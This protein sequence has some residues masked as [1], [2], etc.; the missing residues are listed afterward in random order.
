MASERLQSLEQQL[1]NVTKAQDRIN[2]MLDICAEW[3]LYDVEK[4]KQL[5]DEALALSR[6]EDY[7]LGIGRSLYAIGSSLWQLGD[8]AHA[9][10]FLN[11]A[12]TVAKQMPDQKL[13]GKSNNMLG[14]VYRDMGELSTALGHYLTAQDQ[15]DAI[16]ER[17]PTGVV[18]MNLSL[19]FFAL[20]DYDSALD[21]A[22]KSLS[23]LEE[24]RSEFRL[25][26]I[27]HTLGNIYFK[28]NDFE[29]A[30]TYF[31]KGLELTQASTSP[32]ALALSGIGKVRFMQKDFDKAENYLL[33][34]KAISEE[35]HFI[36]SKIVASFYLGRLYANKNNHSLAVLEYNTALGSA[37]LHGRKHDEMSVH[38][39]L[40]KCYEVM[41]DTASAYYHL[42]SFSELRDTIFEMEGITQLRNRKVLHDIE[43]AR[44]EREL[45]LRTAVVKQQFLAN[46]SHEI[47][48]PM[49]A[50][51]GMTRLL[52]EKKHFPEQE[53]YLKA[54][55]TSSDN[56]LVI[57]NDILDISKIESGKFQIEAI[58][59]SL[60]T[61]VQGVHQTLRL[62]AAEKELEFSYHVEQAIP[63][64]LIGDP[65]RLSQVLINLAGNAIKFT[66][67]GDVKIAVVNKSKDEQQVLLKI[68]VIDSGVGIDEQYVYNLFQKFTQ[69]GSDTARKYG[70]TGLGLSISKQLV[71]LMGG[72]ISVQSKA[73]QG[74]TFTVELPLQINDTQMLMDSVVEEISNQQISSLANKKVLLVED[75]EFNQILA[76]DTLRDM[77]DS[78]QIDVALNGKVAVEKATA[79]LYDL[80]LMDIQ[81]PIM[82]GVQ[83]TE[84]IRSTMK[85]P[86]SLV[87]I[88]AMTANVM[89]EDIDQ[90]FAIGMNDYISKPFTPHVLLHKM[91]KF[92]GASSTR[93]LQVSNEGDGY[94]DAREKRYSDLKFLDGITKGDLTKQKKYI[95]IFLRNAPQLLADAK[96]SLSINDRERLRVQV[97]SLKSQLSYM[98]VKEDASNVQAFEKE[99][100]DETVAL[101]KL[102]KRYQKLQLVCEKTFAE[103]RE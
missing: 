69:A 48:T 61:V 81:M 76:L 62:K 11:E 97:H 58:P 66:D 67:T 46:M 59:F 14:N 55:K 50:I 28:K 54:I 5:A 90:Y 40:A 77:S 71:S 32:H 94:I 4:A 13:N 16:A 3:R 102:E 10:N 80:I 9:V 60:R 84:V 91:S 49:N 85:P 82:T 30:L 92:L 8:Y 53:R 26:S 33:K 65:T 43:V 51:I 41:G 39:Y 19:I 103:V 89:R 15:F 1:L 57:I 98:G 79:T 29:N 70:G 2:V 12:L 34:A 35:F 75:N 42:K 83:A 93:T 86:F 38:E 47:R 74:S 96:H 37:M 72:A 25:F 31:Y 73:G 24:E 45:A 20:G 68:Q 64:I 52:Q 99:C 56:L 78:L 100:A 22:L 6:A 21:N 63:D 101:E 17:Q 27:Y 23:I 36:E 44:K 18:M 7:P 88:I 87:P 95:E